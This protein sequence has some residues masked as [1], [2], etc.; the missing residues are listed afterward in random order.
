[1]QKVS[2]NMVLAREDDAGPGKEVIEMLSTLK[3]AALVAGFVTLAPVAPLL[4]GDGSAA[5]AHSYVSGSVVIGGPAAVFGFSYGNPFPVTHVH[6]Y[7]VAC[8]VGPLY[9][10]P[11]Y[12][13][14]GHFHPGYSYYGYS[15]PGYYHPRPVRYYAPAPGYRYKVRGHGHHGY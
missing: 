15:S 14:Y 12:G 2:L 13:V 4:S 7:P 9:Y 6:Y 8:S 1:M 11:A 3:K 10:Y 5:Y